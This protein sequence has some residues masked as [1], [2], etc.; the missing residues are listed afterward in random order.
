MSE[1][2]NMINSNKITFTLLLFLFSVFIILR[3]IMGINHF[4]HYDDLYAPFLLRDIGNYS[5]EKTINQLEKYG[6]NS[7]ILSIYFEI[8][9]T[10]FGLIFLKY[11]IG[12]IA[13]AKTSTFAP[14]QFYI[15]GLLNW[16]ELDYKYTLF[17]IRLPSALL[18]FAFIIIAIRYL[19]QVKVIKNNKGIILFLIYPLISW[20]FLIYSSQAENYIVGLI[21]IPIMLIFLENVKSNE[22]NYKNLFKFNLAIFLSIFSSY[23]LIW[24]LPAL[25]VTYLYQLVDNNLMKKREKIISFISTLVLS[26]LSF[27]LV[28]YIFIKKLL[29]NLTNGE[30]KLGIGWNAGVNNEFQYYFN[31]DE[32]FLSIIDFIIF[33]GKNVNKIIWSMF[34]GGNYSDFIINLSNT[35]FIFLLF[36]GFYLTSNIRKLRYLSIFGLI[37]F[38]TWLF[39][40]ANG[41]LA[42]SP[43]RHSLIYMSLVWIYIGIA[44]NHIFTNENKYN[45][46]K[47]LTAAFLFSSVGLFINDFGSQYN[48]RKNIILETNLIEYIKKNQPDFI[49]SSN[50]TLDL[51]FD[52][53]IKDKY[54]VKFFNQPPTYFQFKAKNP[55]NNEIL[56]MCLS[57]KDCFDINT[58][59]KISEQQ[60]IN[61][62]D[63]QFEN[64]SSTKSNTSICFGNYTVNGTN[65]SNIYIFKKPKI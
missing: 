25:L 59:R 58:I 12:P 18:S 28:Y 62:T 2:K 45:Y 56:F 65:E 54:E 61:L 51:N 21:F 44:L 37:A 9:G 19:K 60:S 16:I 47:F 41:I 20:M 27:L 26:T 43:T 5:L 40:I 46:I 49:Y 36:L 53:Y 6:L 24:F 35:F 4:T 42:F 52:R 11:I 7:K 1:L 22:F 31:N 29:V 55:Q 38:I 15:T 30:M 13:V 23:Q 14:L 64:H 17:W 33:I 39:F 3:I 8:F 50:F 63:F 48:S 57:Y 10:E 32:I 34:G